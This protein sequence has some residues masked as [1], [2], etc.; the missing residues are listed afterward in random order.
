MNTKKILAVMAVLIMAASCSVV[1]PAGE[2]V[3]IEAHDTQ[4][5]DLKVGEVAATKMSGYYDMNDALKQV[6]PTVKK[7]VNEGAATQ[8]MSTDEFVEYLCSMLSDKSGKLLKKIMADPEGTKITKSDLISVANE[9]LSQSYVTINDI[10]FN[11]SYEVLNATKRIADKE[12][13]N[14]N[15]ANAKIMLTVDV[16]AYQMSLVLQNAELNIRSIEESTI[17]FTPSKTGVSTNGEVNI[18]FSGKSNFINSA[19]QTIEEI[20]VMS[21]ETKDFNLPLT[22]KESV[23]FNLSTPE[24][25][26]LPSTVGEVKDTNLMASISTEA[27]VSSTNKALN[28]YFSGMNMS[29]SDSSVLPA[30][31]EYAAA[32]K[33]IS[34]N[35]YETTLF[36]TDAETQEPKKIGTICTGNMIDAVDFDHK[37]ITISGYI[38]L[39][40]P[41]MYFCMAISQEETEA[42]TGRVVESNLGE[43]S[44]PILDELVGVY[45][46]QFDKDSYIINVNGTE[47]DLTEFMKEIEGSDV[48]YGAD[49]ILTEEEVKQFDKDVSKTA[50]AL[51]FDIIGFN[52]ENLNTNPEPQPGPVG[53]INDNLLIIFVIVI[54][55]IIAIAILAFTRKGPSA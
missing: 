39:N 19:A 8:G 50:Y 9:F 17:S 47:Y 41:S 32:D 10:N 29:Y 4:V 21:T 3:G 24:G 23:A 11:I 55:A 14:I 20:I 1:I 15:T 26:V 27:K 49:Y 37:G 25:F 35:H 42:G 5:T 46:I 18:I 36:Y 51:N 13:R 16:S 2:T 44:F 22:I 52:G 6:G 33:Y 7:L 48:R 30:T 28:D 12:Y 43:D 45:I 31:V 40:E 53:P 34:E 38:D 54:A